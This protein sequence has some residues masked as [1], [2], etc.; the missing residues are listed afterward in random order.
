MLLVVKE[1]EAIPVSR[2]P[3]G[4]PREQ[5]PI[6]EKKETLEDQVYQVL[7]VRKA[8]LVSAVTPDCQ[9][10]MDALESLGHQVLRENLASQEAQVVLEV[11]D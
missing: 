8:S 2:D 4:P 7:Q 3:Q 5:R 10:Q 6:R 1:R 9:E 11:Q